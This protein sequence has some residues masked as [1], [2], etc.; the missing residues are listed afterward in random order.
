MSTQ[1][2]EITDRLHELLPPRHLGVLGSAS[3]VHPG[4]EAACVAIGERLASIDSLA[5]VT[6]GRGGVGQS[7]SGSVFQTRVANHEDPHVYHLLPDGYPRPAVGDA[8]YV[9][10][11]MIERREILGR[12]AKVYLVIEGGPGTEYEAG[13]ALSKG[14]SV[15]PVARFGGYSL[16]LFGTMSAPPRVA[17]HDWS[18]LAAERIPLDELAEAVLSIV[19]TLVDA[20]LPG[21]LE[22]NQRVRQPPC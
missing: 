21:G 9:G 2:D 7:L 5:I 13:V 8:L 14:A 6:G 10:S 20:N 3:C 17:T 19:A 18:L 4:T 12:V 22:W 15:V 1:F 11:N 16:E